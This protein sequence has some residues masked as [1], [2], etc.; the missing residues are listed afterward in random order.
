[1]AGL[2]TEGAGFQPV[3]E[4]PGGPARD[5]GFGQHAVERVRRVGEGVQVGRDSGGYE[6]AGVVDV[7]V[8]QAVEIADGDECG[9][10]SAQVCR[11]SRSGIAGYVVFR[12]ESAEVG[13]PAELVGRWPPQRGAG[14]A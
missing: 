11:P 6:P 14:P 10:Q 3:F 13:A 5:R 9:W 1:M 12:I 8:Q 4:Y 7:L 2:V